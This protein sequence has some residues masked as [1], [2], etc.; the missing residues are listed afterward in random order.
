MSR[1]SSL[2]KTCCTLVWAT[3]RLHHYMLYHTT[4]LISRMEPLK[5]LFE[6][7]VLSSRLVCWHLLLPEFDITYITEKSMKGQ[8]IADHLAENLIEG[9][10]PITDLFS[11]KSIVSIYQKKIIPVGG[12]TLMVRQYT[13]EQDRGRSDFSNVGTLLG[14][15]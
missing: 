14:G 5:H 3:Q 6:K 2:E 15:Y 4:L 7:P 12:C 9:Y 13:R 10:Q 11:D 1:D 8:A